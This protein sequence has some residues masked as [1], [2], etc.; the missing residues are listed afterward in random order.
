MSCLVNLIGAFHIYIRIP[1]GE[2]REKKVEIL[3]EQI[4]A[5]KLPKS[6]ERNRHPGPETTE[7]SRKR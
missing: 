7:S 6:E 2:E 5:E 4:T 3:F 1:E